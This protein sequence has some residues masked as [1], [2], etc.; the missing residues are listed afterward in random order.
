MADN[1]RLLHAIC[2]AG[3]RPPEAD[4]E[5]VEEAG[6]AAICSRLD[7][8]A[9][10]A[11]PAWLAAAAQ[12]HHAIVQRLFEA[13]PVLPIRFGTLVD[14]SDLASLLANNRAELSAELERLGGLAE[15]G[16]KIFAEPEAL[17]RAAEQS[18]ADIAALDAEL[19]ASAP[20]RAF[21]LKRQ[22]EAAVAG[23]VQQHAGTVVERVRTT[24]A[25]AAIED[26]ELPLPAVM[27][28]GNDMLA[29]LAFLVRE[30]D[31][32]V[33]AATADRAGRE[34]QVE[35]EI[36]GPWAPYSFVRLNLGAGE[37]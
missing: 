32:D 14:A 37:P 2:A 7:D 8:G 12:R 3:P 28:A 30:S 20:G 25:S 18:D 19:S 17:V 13:A 10:E 9:D 27:P 24:L 4:T 34:A 15:W 29:N 1:R 35:V 6:L 22:R 26:A 33:F 16:A 23:A 36:S 11:D 5:R 21:L 31:S